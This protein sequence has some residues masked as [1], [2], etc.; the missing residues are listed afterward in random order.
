MNA[1]MD[2][3]SVTD[4]YNPSQVSVI[5]QGMR[6]YPA[7]LP[8]DLYD[9]RCEEC[10]VPGK[11]HEHIAVGGRRYSGSIDSAVAMLEVKESDFMAAVSGRPRMSIDRYSELSNFFN[12]VI[13][14][15][16]SV[17][18]LY[19]GE[20]AIPSKWFLPFALKL[21]ESGICLVSGVEPIPRGGIDAPNDLSSKVYS[22]Q[23]WALLDVGNGGHSGGFLYR[24]DKQLA[25]HREERVTRE[26]YAMDLL[27]RVRWEEPPVIVH[28]G[29]NFAIL[30]CSELTNIAHRASLRGCVDWVF[31]PELNKD[32]KT[33]SS[34]VE[35]S[36]NDIHSF[37]VQVNSRAYGDT[38][39][40]G[41]MVK[42]FQRDLVRLKG[43]EVDYFA[44]V[45][46]DLAG[47]R[48]HH[49]LRR[50]QDAPK[51]K[52]LPDGFRPDPRRR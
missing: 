8:G 24:Q 18:Y 46:L 10:G 21:A 29:H 16:R 44:V 22:N 11:T 39:V 2:A 13:R 37:V 23:V 49:Q 31:V 14:S 45:N 43:G 12:S 5:M 19:V 28:R 47:L 4:L 42:D 35:S 48:E 1:S 50:I 32:I 40:R 41:P 3:K 26:H 7:A 52:P 6:G 15:S 33:F 17:R 27:P 30:V 20:G 34:I 51:Y 25:S 38:R 9:H 36:A